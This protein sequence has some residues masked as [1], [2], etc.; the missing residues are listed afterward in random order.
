MVRLDRTNLRLLEQ[1]QQDARTS[2]AEL[3]RNV[4]RAESTVRE[5]IAAL[6][7]DGILKGYSANLDPNK[8]GFR[9][10]ASIRADCD[11]SRVSNVRDRLAAIPQVVR[12]RLMTGPKPLRIE[13]VAEDLAQ[14]EQVVENH[15]APLGLEG[16]EVSLEV[17][18]LVGPRPLPVRASLGIPSQ[19]DDAGLGRVG[20]VSGRS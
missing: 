15:I 16:L 8:V 2:F 18:A 7:R 17:R 13:L 12:A 1:L 5:R 3:A 11:L 9:A 10:Q 14:I 20:L 4:N 6:E 19:G